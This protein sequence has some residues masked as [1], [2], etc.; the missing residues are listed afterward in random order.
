VAPN[1]KI[2]RQLAA[3]QKDA[4]V[5]SQHC[6]ATDAEFQV[7]QQA[8]SQKLT[9]AINKALGREW[10]HDGYPGDGFGQVINQETHG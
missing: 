3:I 1:R 4:V 6:T 5:I 8:F 2:E 10:H 9:N 7:I